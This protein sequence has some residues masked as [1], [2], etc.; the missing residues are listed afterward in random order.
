[1]ITS[2]APIVLARSPLGLSLRAFGALPGRA[3]R[4]G[5]A[6]LFGL[7]ALVLALPLVARAADPVASDAATAQALADL[8]REAEGL[9]ASVLYVVE[10]DGQRAQAKAAEARGKAERGEWDGAVDAWEQ[11]LRAGLKQADRWLI[12]ADFYDKAEGA[13]PRAVAAA[14]LAIAEAAGGE[15]RALAQTRT[16]E[17]LMAAERDDVALAL[18]RRAQASHP[19]PRAANGIAA[20]SGTGLAIRRTLVEADRDLPRLC[21]DLTAAPAAID[22]APYVKIEPAVPV[23]VSATGKRLCIDGLPHGQ[24]VGVTL[25]EGLPTLTGATLARSLTLEARIANRAPRVAFAGNAYILPAR[26]GRDVAVRTVNVDQLWLTLLR[27]NDRGLAG[28]LREHDLGSMVSGGDLRAIAEDSGEKIWEGKLDID[29]A[30]NRETAT[31]IPLATILPDPRPGLYLLAAED[32]L[33]GSTPWW[34]QPSQWLLVTDIGL[35]SA[36]GLDG[37]SV[38]ARSLSSGR[39]LIGASVTLVARNNAEVASAVTDRNGMVRFQPAQLSGRDGKTPTWVMVYGPAGDFAYLDVTGPAFDLS[40][41]G[42]GGR[43]APGPLDAFLYTERGI[44]RPGET[45]H[46][47]GLLRDSGARGLSGLPLTV[48]IL[49]PDGVQVDRQ[50]LSDQGV[51]AYGADI[52]LLKEA[53]SGRWEITAHV[54]PAAPPIG[55]VSFM[56]E[57]FV[58]QTMEVTL[59]T[60][61]TAL[62]LT[63]DDPSAATASVAVQAD[64]FYGAPVASQPVTSEVVLSADPEPFAAFKGFTFGLA[65]EEVEPRRFDLEPTQTDAKGAATLAVTLDGAPDTSHPLRA[66]VRTSVIDAG[67]RGAA[68]TLVLPVRHQPMAVGIKARFEGDTLAEGATPVFDLA[69]VNPAGAPV[70]QRPLDWV[71]YEEVSRYTWYENGGAW[72]YRRTVSDEVRASGRVMTAANGLAEV[73]VPVG[74]GA[75]RLEVSDGGGSLAAS[76]QRF[77]AGWWVAGADSR[78]TPDTLKVTREAEAYRPG[79]RARLRLEAPFAGHALVS[80][81]TDRLLDVLDVPLPEGGLTVELPVTEAWGVGAYVVVTAFRPGENAGLRGPGRAMGVAWVPVDMTRRTLSVALD[82]PQTVLPRQRLEVPVQVAGGQGPVFLTL[83]AVDEG[84]L[85]LTDFQSPDPVAYYYGKRSLGL[86]Y[87]DAYGRLLEGTNARPGRLREGGDASGRHLMGLPRSSVETVSLFSGIVAVGKDGRAVVPVDIPDFTGRLRLMAVAFSGAGVGHGEAAVTVRDPMVAMATLPRFLAP[88]DRSFLSVSLD[89]IDGPAGVWT[90]AAVG[91]GALSVPE[92]PRAV[93]LA[94]GGRD[95]VRLAVEGRSPGPGTLRLAI[96]APTGERREKTWSFDVRPAA[97]RMTLTHRLDLGG[98]GRARLDG[99]L[100]EGFFRQGVEGALTL[101]SVPNLD[102]IGNASALRAYPY[103]CLEQTV[104]RAWVALYGHDLDTPA[105]WKGWSGKDVLATEIARVIALQRPDGGFALW[106]SSGGLD[107]WLSAYALEFLLRAREEKAAVPDFVVERGLAYLDDAIADGDFSDAGLPAAAYAHYVLARAGA[108]DLGR[109]RYFAD[110][111][112]AR[113]P[114]P[115]A[116]VQTAAAL[117]LLGDGPRASAALKQGLGDRARLVS[118]R[119]DWDYGSALRDRAATLALGIET[120]LLG[121]DALATAD[122]LAD[123]LARTPHP[124]TQERGWLVLAAR[125][126]ARQQGSV[127]ATVDGVGVDSGRTTVTLP[128]SVQ[129]LGEGVEIV[130][131]GD[132]ALRVVASLDGQPEAPPPAASE[133]LTIDRRFLTLAGEAVDPTKVRQNDLL[134]ALIT[135]SA[136]DPKVIARERGNRLLVVDLLPAGVEI[137]NPRIGA[138]APGSEGLSWLPELTDTTHVEARDDRYV[139][140]V[141]ID[142][143]TPKFTLAYVVRAVSPGS[144]VV[145]GAAVEDMDRPALRANQGAGRLS[146]TAR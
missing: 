92:G 19:T 17:L 14:F 55:R 62:D 81:V 114:T 137:E 42:V 66:L 52:P 146:I 142:A 22:L 75:F 18:F 44:Y 67:G 57:D 98:R 129:D 15:A 134:V 26:G 141:D 3:R 40:D 88:G 135:G 60:T 111:Y 78:D 27:V 63:T 121:D 38:F 80:V 83:A 140:S 51:G 7:I 136:T 104:S 93:D 127:V 76:S 4:L 77:R 32:R 108:V 100:L 68:R 119:D 106:S 87:R 94:K 115:L 64:Y 126:L 33:R 23:A 138:G 47:S 71:L 120:G 70:A 125:A 145:P 49:R 105:L 1:M 144:F 99:G 8:G 13:E 24:T 11:A 41:R 122:T 103:G 25:R 97:P 95:L 72:N 84:I 12:L 43:E 128:L 113:M 131:G 86:A 58:P 102:P 29:A 28:L 48:K 110:T 117:S 139:A 16:A 56:V 130:N 2:G 59:K 53:R 116:R 73:A 69:A 50:V 85:Q 54:D 96:T 35:Q 61:A 10:N 31:A 5:I 118:D 20:L 74:F 79:E 6:T 109:L 89:N 107:P 112:L 133:G 37:L 46:L 124:S 143:K 45:V 21:L 132:R 65:Q 90:L 36:V 9:K 39:A 123:T 101:S 91:E 82:A 34:N 30:L